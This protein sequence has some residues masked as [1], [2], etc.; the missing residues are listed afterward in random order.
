MSIRWVYRAYP[1]VYRSGKRQNQRNPMNHIS[2]NGLF[3]NDFGQ[4]C[5]LC[6][7]PI[8]ARWSKFDHPRSCQSATDVYKDS[9]IALRT[10]KSRTSEF[11]ACKQQDHNRSSAR[12]CFRW[13]FFLLSDALWVQ[14]PSQDLDCST[15]RSISL[16]S[17][18]VYAFQNQ[19]V[20]LVLD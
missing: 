5:G 20:R 8:S 11:K 14:T 12:Y 2:T 3:S 16:F 7:S 13:F 9:G 1:D 15:A 6:I 19:K 18:F 4:F 17:L 10:S